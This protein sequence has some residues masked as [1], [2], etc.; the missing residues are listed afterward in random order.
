MLR[1]SISTFLSVCLLAPLFLIPDAASAC[2]GPLGGVVQGGRC[3]VWL[4]KPKSFK[5][6]WIG[7]DR[8][9]IPV[10]AKNIWHRCSGNRPGASG[11]GSIRM[12]TGKGQCE[13]HGFNAGFDY[14]LP[15][16]PIGAF[17]FKATWPKGYSTCATE[18]VGHDC[19]PEPKYEIRPV[20]FQVNRLAWIDFKGMVKIKN[21][22]KGW[23][24]KG[25]TKKVVGGGCGPFGCSG[26]IKVI[27][28]KF[29]TSTKRGYWP[30]YSFADC[31]SRK[32]GSFR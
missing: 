4:E 18:S 21:W 10:Q 12:S 5:Q 24:P 19:T 31:R 9:D 11:C 22:N 15:K 25:F 17:K 26:G 23:C 3:L 20:L 13:S 27:C 16:T 29:A 28:K 32:I 8:R 30:E 14:E 1:L 7:K 6:K 2:D